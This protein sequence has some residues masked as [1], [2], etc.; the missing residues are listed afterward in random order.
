MPS[1]IKIKPPMI[2]I[3]KMEFRTRNHNGKIGVFPEKILIDPTNEM[4]LIYKK[5]DNPQ[6]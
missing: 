3:P 2:M 5:T 1:N 4:K 6:R